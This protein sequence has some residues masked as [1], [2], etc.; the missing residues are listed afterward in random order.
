[1]SG[2]IKASGCN[3]MF[4]TCSSDIAEAMA[5][6]FAPSTILP[7]GLSRLLIET[8]FAIGPRMEQPI[9]SRKRNGL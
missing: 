6:R 1:S 3:K 2:T 4:K 9:S 7:L 8:D 5:L